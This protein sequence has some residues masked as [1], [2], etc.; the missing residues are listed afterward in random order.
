[1][2]QSQSGADSGSQY[3]AP[4]DQQEQAAPDAQDTA[5]TLFISRDHLPDGM[6]AKAGDVLKF[7]VV[8]MDKDGDLEIEY[9]DGNGVEENGQDDQSFGSGLKDAM[10]GDQIR[11]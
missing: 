6:D 1:M 11:G 8:G 3:S 10:A 7:K 9:D 2:D 4:D 5:K